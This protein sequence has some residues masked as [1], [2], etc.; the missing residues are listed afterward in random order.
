MDSRFALGE[1]LE[2]LE[3]DDPGLF[4]EEDSDCEEAG[5]FDYL[6][7]ASGDLMSALSSEEALDDEEEGDSTSTDEA[8]SSELATVPD[9]G[10]IFSY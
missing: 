5:I 7:E 10:K 8:S 6:P 9:A 3:D 1:V 2:R 4:S